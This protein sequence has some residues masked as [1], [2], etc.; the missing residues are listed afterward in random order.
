MAHLHLPASIAIIIAAL[1]IVIQAIAVPDDSSTTKW[2]QHEKRAI[3]PPVSTT[4]E[5]PFP[6][7]PPEQIPH[8]PN[9]NRH[10]FSSILPPEAKL[11]NITIVPQGGSHGEG[12]RNIAY[13]TDPTNL[14][15]L[16]AVTINVTSSKSSSYRFGIFLPNEWTGRFLA[17]G[18][19]GFA[20]GINWLD[21]A[22]GTHYHMA[23][24]SSDLG[25]NSSATDTSW[26]INAPEKKTDWGWRALHGTV[27]LGKKLTASYYNVPKVSYSYYSGCSTGGR[28]GLR[29]IQ[30]FPD[31]FDGVLIGAPAWWTSHLNN[32]ITQIGMYNLPNTSSSYVSN[33]LLKVV[34]KEVVKQCDEADGV[35]DGIIMRPDL[36]HFNSS[37]LLCPP[38]Y[39]FPANKSLTTCLTR[40]QLATLQK[41]YSPH[42]HSSTD[43]LIYP[44]LTLGSEAQW[45][46]I[47]NNNGTPSPFGVGYQRNFLYDNATWNY[48]TSYSDS[49]V[50]LADRLDPGQATADHYN[51]SAYKSRGGKVILYHG[52]ADGLVPTK[53]T[54][55]YYNRTIR[56]LGGDLTTLSG[57]RNTT[58][59]FKLFLVPGLQHCWSTPSGVDAPWNLG[60][61]FQAG[62]MGSGFYSVPGFEGKVKYDGLLALV[63]WREEGREVRQLVATG[64]RDG[65]NVT[66]GVKRQRAN[67]RAGAVIPSRQLQ[68]RQFARHLTTETSSTTSSP[69]PVTPFRKQ[70]KEQAKALKKSGAKKKKSSDNQTVPGWEL[71]VGIEIHAQLN[72]SAKLFSSATTSFN[73]LPNTHQVSKWDRKHYF[74]W[75]QPSGYQITQFYEPFARDGHITLYARDGIASEDGEVVKVGIKQVQMEQDTAKT[76]A[77]PGDTQWLDF[78]RVGVPL[79]EIITLPEIH[80]PATAAA[81][82]RKVQMVLGSVDAC[83]SGLEEGGLRADVNVSVRRV[84]DNGQPMGPLGT[85]T[86]IKNLSSFKAVE[87]AIIAERDR[88]I[89]LLQEGGEVK[90]ETRGWSLGSTETRRLR[91]KEGEVDYRYM[92]DP[93]LGPVVIAPELVTRL[94]ETMGVLPDE[95]AD[96]LMERYNLSAKDALSLMLLDGGARVQYFYNV[97]DSLEE[98]MEADGQTVPERAEHAT[99][100]ANWCLHELGKLTDSASSSESTSNLEMTPLGES[101]LVPSSSLAA[102]LFHLHSRKITAKVA[103]DLLWAVYRGEVAEG[104]VTNYIDTNN[105]WFKELSEDEY[106]QLANDVIEGEEKVLGEFVKFKQGKSKAYPQGKLM[107]LVGKMMRNGPEGRVEAAGAERVLR[108]VVEKYLEDKE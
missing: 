16:C 13:P 28:Q 87:D 108:A 21:M 57:L 26:A 67:A 4:S 8:H 61:A 64:W 2:F 11:E 96:S 19:G 15:G 42:H 6:T 23:T 106:A 33:D 17:V 45:P 107:Y 49:C 102:I 32:Y 104:E 79:I 52:L 91:G 85:R 82:V 101:P 25:H 84:D 90:G 65:L 89:K 78:N 9:C 70:L 37:R 51:I 86:E 95:E 5:P 50:D 80:H 35:K 100:A 3:P 29:E 22:P 83:V 12:K 20:G 99:L 41:V 36:C 66:G 98:R 48:T 10:F 105:L 34:A 75:D 63:K 59:F 31:S 38:D 43:E 69:P 1:A 93:D 14:P 97:L 60:G 73:D 58:S 30:E 39:H 94:R 71:T 76:T 74:H 77:Q 62:V 88:Q 81:L 46:L 53:G 44:G 24:V 40:P 47:L 27:V 68:P 18:N 54:E 55:L 7:P 72:T 103:K 56:S 92:P